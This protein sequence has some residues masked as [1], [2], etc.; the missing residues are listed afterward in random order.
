MGNTLGSRKITVN[1]SV[2]SV[3]PVVWRFQ[4]PGDMISDTSAAS[5][6]PESHLPIQI[7]P[8]ELVTISEL[9]P[10]TDRQSLETNKPESHLPLRNMPPELATIPELEPTTDQQSPKTKKQ[11]TFLQEP[12]KDQDQR[13]PKTKKQESPFAV[14]NKP[15]E[16]VTIPE[17]P[18]TDQHQNSPETKK[19]ESPLPL[20]NKPP[21]LVTIPELEPTTQHSP[22]AKKLES[23]LSLRNISPELVTIQEL[24]SKTDQ[25]SPKSKKLQSHLSLRNI[26]PELVTIP[27]LEPK[28]DQHSPKTKKLESPL[29]VQNK[30]PEV[31]S[32]TYLLSPEEPKGPPPSQEKPKTPS[33]SLDTV[34][35]RHLKRVASAIPWVG[36]VLQTK[37]SNFEDFY[38]CDRQLGAGEFGRTFLCVEKAT[39][40]EYAFKSIEKRK[41][42]S[43][44]DA[45]DVRREIQIMHHLAGQPNVISIKEAYEN[46]EA[47]CIVMEL[48]EGGDLSEAICWGRN[49]GDRKAA[50]LT[51]K[52]VE[53][54]EACHSL[55][56]MHRD[57][58]LDNFL[59]V[60]WEDDAPLK[61]IDFGLSVFFKP[62]DKF[63]DVVGTPYF[64]APEVFKKRYGPEAD[65][66]SAG[67]ILYFLL[68]GSL[69]F[70]GDSEEEIFKMVLHDHLDF[71]SDPW[72]SISEGAKD[73]VNRMLDK[74]PSRRISAHDILRHPWVQLGS[75]VLSLKPS[76]EINSF[77][78]EAAILIAQSLSQ[79]EIAGLKERFKM[80]DK[81]KRG[82]ITYKELMAELEQCGDHLKGLS[83]LRPTVSL[84]ANNHLKTEL[85][86]KK[87][88]LKK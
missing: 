30:P 75:K 38:T 46:A 3:L 6:E 53:A 55:G 20:R 9:E 70:K 47:V 59:F 2:P 72:P 61:I 67:V 65:V 83:V 35:P 77:K 82:K 36:S 49:Y 69:P 87:K 41:I 18:T 32:R 24:E 34:K 58:K 68:S 40:K 14:Q 60:N 39:G 12:I 19:P 86:L 28:P 80:E 42:I 78:K 1:G 54:L 48:C 88:Y 10:T 31:E 16:L 73:L 79:E 8:L 27:E 22:K 84:F 11:V 50:T 37:T 64:V 57:I 5:K 74:E 45:E 62:E 21:E 43:D 29:P 76:S 23:R 51:R 26:P 56:V 17:E 63:S 44:V 66:W 85:V 4:Y 15:P 71:S 81:Y 7:K 52:I 33:A 25:H 13:S